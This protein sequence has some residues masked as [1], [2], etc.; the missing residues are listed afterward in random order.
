MDDKR[1]Y[2]FRI[3]TGDL[4]VVLHEKEASAQQQLMHRLRKGRYSTYF[5]MDGEL[6]EVTEL[7]LTE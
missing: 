6:K 7:A 3:N 5:L 4:P 1:Q 2:L